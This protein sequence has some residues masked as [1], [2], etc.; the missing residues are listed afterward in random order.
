MSALH[1]RVGGTQHFYHS[2]WGLTARFR[3]DGTH[4]IYEEIG[5]ECLLALVPRMLL[6]F[7]GQAIHLIRVR[8]PL[9]LPRRYGFPFDRH[10]WFVDRAGVEH[11]YIIDYYFNPD[12]ALAASGTPLPGN[13]VGGPARLT[14]SIFV[15]VR[16]AVDDVWA[17]VDRLRKLPGRLWDGVRRPR[18]VAEGLDP[19]K[20]GPATAAALSMLHS[21]NV[22]EAE[23]TVVAQAPPP[24][25]AAP[26]AAA[27]GFSAQFAAVD[28]K[29]KPFLDA[30]QA[31]ASEEER[32]TAYVGLSYCT[33]SVVCPGE[34]RSF[35]DAVEASNSAGGVGGGGAAGGAEEASFLAMNQCV[36][37][38]MAA[39]R[40]AAEPA[41][42]NTQLR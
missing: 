5:R 41:A 40:Q 36:V 31:A 17:A 4:E 8:Y 24:A 14:S 34:A 33:G 32:R 38:K 13:A 6:L 37:G 30:L 35:M 7:C 20:A 10:D 3:D 2:G 21:S 28:T 15:D 26:A 25:A 42:A 27:S 23:P 29:C 16:P 9:L 18:W 39:A 12:P 1:R 22:T 19:S 11:R